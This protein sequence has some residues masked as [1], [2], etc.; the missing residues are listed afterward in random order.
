M[1][2]SRRCFLLCLPDSFVAGTSCAQN[3]LPGKSPPNLGSNW[4]VRFP[5]VKALAA[6][7]HSQLFCVSLKNTNYPF[8]CNFWWRKPGQF[9]YLP[10]VAV[11]PGA[12][13]IPGHAH[14]FPLGSFSTSA[15]CRGEAHLQP[16]AQAGAHRPSSA[17]S[18][19]SQTVTR[20]CCW[21]LP[22]STASQC[23]SSSAVGSLLKSPALRDPVLPA[24]SPHRSSTPSPH[25]YPYRRLGPAVAKAAP[26]LPAPPT[27][28]Q[29]M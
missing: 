6:K 26:P 21:L 18:F 24:S 14:L 2:H 27:R 10:E 29:A 19:L 13:V 8:W 17:L 12:A 23:C 15:G 16:L 7:T 22:L 1:L 28:S 11:L 20:L 25:Q 4:M 5:L 3:R 9:F